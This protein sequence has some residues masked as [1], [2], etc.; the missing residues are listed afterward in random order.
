MAK[1]QHIAI[2]DI[3]T[4]GLQTRLRIDA[5][6]VRDYAEAEEKRGAV[7]PPVVVYF[8][9]AK[10]WLAD[11]FHRLASARQ[12]GRKKIAA[13]VREGGRVDALRFALGANSAH[14][15]RRSNADKANAVRVAYAHRIE[16]GLGEVPSARAVAEMCGVSHEFARLQLSTV[17]SWREATERTGRDGK[18]RTVPPIPTRKPSEN[19]I[20]SAPPV[21]PGTPPAPPERP[22]RARDRVREEDEVSY[23][24]VPTLPP[25]PVRGRVQAPP[26][27]EPDGP[28]DGR[29]KPIPPQL[30]ELWNRRE[31]VQALATAV[32]RVRVAVRDAQNGGDP[33]F[34]ELNF[35]SVSAHLDRAYAELD[36]AKPWCVCPMCQG[37]GCRACKGRGLMG[38]HRFD[39]VVPRDLR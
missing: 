10:H 37:I 22:S 35:S 21:R 27:D 28:A 34:A 9:G 7:L 8:D 1:T 30:A 39:A 36:A 15:L 20:L 16:L 38:R 32:S 13:E 23:G 5:E 24:T 4:E 31:E 18:V 3:V 11:G 12:L 25:P 33:L 29:G 26:P 2:A 14:G 19:G 17:D 6:T